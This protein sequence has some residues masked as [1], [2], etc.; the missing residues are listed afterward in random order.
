MADAIVHSYAGRN[1]WEVGR[2]S[3]QRVIPEGYLMSRLNPYVPTL[4][5]AY[6]T[7]YTKDGAYVGNTRGGAVRVN[8]DGTPF[9]WSVLEKRTVFVRSIPYPQNDTKRYEVLQPMRDNYE[10]YKAGTTTAGFLDYEVQALR[11]LATD[12]YRELELNANA[13]GVELKAASTADTNG[14][15]MTTFGTSAGPIGAI[16]S[17][18]GWLIQALSGKKK[19]TKELQT[20][21]EKAQKDL[22]EI[23]AIYNVYAPKTQ[24]KWLLPALAI[25]GGILLALKK[26]SGK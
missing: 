13:L 23:S 6:D 20:T 25:G 9:D 3:I 15:L 11:N 21:L 4:G 22:T 7:Y 12:Y 18:T 2:D 26:R 17:A 10:A 14:V 19:L 1:L 24:N 5:V 16:V 8:P